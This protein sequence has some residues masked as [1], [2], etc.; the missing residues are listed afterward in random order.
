MCRSIKTLFHTNPPPT[1]ADIYAASL[2]Y[3]RKISGYRQPSKTN[4]PAFEQA[5]QEIAL[6]TQKLMNSLET[7]APTRQ[8]Q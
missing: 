5:V 6:A 4:E 1:E 7:S 3:V 8:R 2:Q